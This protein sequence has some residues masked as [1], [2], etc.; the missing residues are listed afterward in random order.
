MFGTT[1]GR[2]RQAVGVTAIFVLSAA[3]ANPAASQDAVILGE[4]EAQSAEPFS[5][6]SGLRPLSGRYALGE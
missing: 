3:L 2:L 4:P 1:L 5:H 6:I